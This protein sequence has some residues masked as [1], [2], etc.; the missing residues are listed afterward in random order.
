MK[1]VCLGSAEGTPEQLKGEYKAAESFGETRLG[2]AHLFYRYFIKIRYLAYEEIVR[3]Y[4]R[5]ESGE[6]GE[7]LLMESYLMVESADGTLHKL[8]MERE[9]NVR[10]VLAKLENLRENIIIGFDRP[11]QS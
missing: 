10:N 6:S 9:V 11:S 4:L 8:R 2:E 7:F 5:Q 3:A 1:F